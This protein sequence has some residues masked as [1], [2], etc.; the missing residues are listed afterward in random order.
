[1][2][3]SMRTQSLL[4]I[5]L[6]LL[7]GLSS[8]DFFSSSS[9]AAALRRATGWPFEVIVVMDQTYWKGEAGQ[10]LKEQ[11]EEA[12]PALPQYEPSMRLTYTEP[13]RFNGLLRYVRNILIVTVDPNKYTRSGFKVEVNQWATGQSVVYLY[14]P[15]TAALTEY[16][17]MNEGR[18]VAHFNTVERNRWITGFGSRN[19]AWVN[20]RLQEQFGISL[21]VPED[22]MASKDT[23][24]FLWVSNNA[25]RA[26]MDVLVYSFPYTTDQAFTQDNLVAMRDSVLMRNVPGSFPNSYMS[27]EKRGGLLYEPITLRGK[28]CGVLR[29]LWRVE[30][31]KMGGP[32][33]SHAFLDEKQRKVIVVEAFVF[34]PESKKANL[35][36]RLEASLFTLRFVRETGDLS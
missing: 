1:M 33:V 15:T 5:C 24:E 28:Y 34:A 35:I 21:F 20:K 22:M 14:A 4:F 8:C 3:Q 9:P 31:D 26:R 2:N 19:S 18:L 10:L 32:F 27:T 30:G 13:T 6:G 23:T 17:L 25:K 36:R 29:G 11:L 12:V 7:V 16:L